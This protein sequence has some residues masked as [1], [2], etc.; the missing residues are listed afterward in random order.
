MESLPEQ[1]LTVEPDVT[2]LTKLS[3]QSIYNAI[4]RGELRAVRFGRAVRVPASAVAEWIA[5]RM[6]QATAA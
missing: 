3:S 5:K 6:Q 2:G 1:L 4:N